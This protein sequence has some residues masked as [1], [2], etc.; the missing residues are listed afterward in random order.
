MA[1]ILD[2]VSMCF[3]M[4]HIKSSNF[5]VAAASPRANNIVFFKLHWLAAKHFQQIY[6]LLWKPGWSTTLRLLFLLFL[7][8]Y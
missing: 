2:K 6:N 5:P 4:R 8:T 7:Y 3:A 1:A